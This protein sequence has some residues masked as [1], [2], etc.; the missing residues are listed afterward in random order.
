MGYFDTTPREAVERL[1]NE[2]KKEYDSYKANNEFYALVISNGVLLND[3]LS[4]LIT[5]HL[6]REFTI[7]P[8]QGA[9]TKAAEQEYI[10]SIITSNKNSKGKKYAFQ[11]KLLGKNSPHRGLPTPCFDYIIEN[12]GPAN[13]AA[14]EASR[15]TDFK[16][17]AKHFNQRLVDCYTTFITT[18]TN[19]SPPRVG[20]IYRVRLGPSRTK[21]TT[22]NM[23]YGTALS[24][25]NDLGI[26]AKDWYTANEPVNFK[27]YQ[28]ACTRLEGFFKRASI[29]Q[30]QA[31]GALKREKTRIDYIL[32]HA[33][34]LGHKIWDT[35]YKM[36]FFGIRKKSNTLTNKFD[37]VLGV[38][39]VDENGDRHEK[40]W[41]GTTLP[42]AN[43]LENTWK[44]AS[45]KICDPNK[46]KCPSGILS[47]QK[48]MTTAAGWAR[49][50]RSVTKGYYGAQKTDVDGNF[51]PMSLYESEFG[52]GT[53]EDAPGD[54]G[55]AILQEG[56]YLDKWKR[57][58]HTTY[59]ALRQ[60]NKIPVYR[61]KNND[62]TY[63]KDSDTI[64]MS[65]IFYINIHKAGLNSKYINNWSAGCQ[66]HATR[67]GFDDMMA[68]VDLQLKHKDK[69]G[70]LFSYT[71]IDQ[72]YTPNATVAW[73][74]P[75]TTQLAMGSTSTKPTG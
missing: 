48:Y 70:E 21:N 4:S 20:D 55:V 35:P 41:K 31:A 66:V 5:G 30:L 12:A 68:L 6:A 9:L 56:Q 59:T 39:Y 72:W 10:D 25:E 23:E 60:A 50:D 47:G 8:A 73:E 43:Y 61:D 27:P 62:K 36:W 67:A 16:A 37:D 24:R 64:D 44:D 52:S 40:Y 3:Y 34:N 75:T 32:E 69:A 57:G 54:K 2:S 38:T 1:F 74:V 33:E 26:A 15:R 51:I 45:W 53:Q 42:G 22:Y 63:D 14:T 28:Q 46:S 11:A 7:R 65:R 13:T 58:R 71:L 49:A 19:S 29:E 17:F 18:E